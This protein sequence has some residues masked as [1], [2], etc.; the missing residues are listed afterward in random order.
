[1][2]NRQDSRQVEPS[3][4]GDCAGDRATLLVIVLS[5]RAGAGVQD[6]C[7]AVVGR[8]LAVAT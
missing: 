1:L 7:T 4:C 6:C 3:A 2:R 8:F 5:E